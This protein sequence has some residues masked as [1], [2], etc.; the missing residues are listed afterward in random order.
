MGFEFSRS[1]IRNRRGIDKRLIKISDLALSISEV[2]FGVPKTGGLR[3]AEDQNKLY[4]MGKSQRDGII[5]LSQHQLGKA[6]D[7]YAFVDG[8]ASWDKEHLTA[9]ALAMLKAAQFYNVRLLWGG[10]WT[11]SF[12]DMPHFYLID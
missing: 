8:R 10:F 5:R 2:D 9:V 1:S 11:G 3:S 12:V 6:L 7:V 4:L